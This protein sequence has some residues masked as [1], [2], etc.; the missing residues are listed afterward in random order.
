MYKQKLYRTDPPL[1]W[2]S[3]EGFGFFTCYTHPRSNESKFPTEEERRPQLQ[4]AVRPWPGGGLFQQE[5]GDGRRHQCA[6][7]AARGGEPGVGRHTDRDTSPGR[8]SS[9]PWFQEQANKLS[10]RAHD[11]SEPQR[12]STWPAASARI[13]EVGRWRMCRSSPRHAGKEA[14]MPCASMKVQ[15]QA[16]LLCFFTCLIIQPVVV[17]TEPRFLN[18]QGFKRFFQIM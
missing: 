8:W 16:M 9:G 15:C 12:A 2:D 6:R 18:P 17:A 13:T 11:R 1:T 5:H 10:L 3:G 14:L 4:F 7:P